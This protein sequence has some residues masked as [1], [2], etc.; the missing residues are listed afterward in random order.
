[1]C[2]F[3]IGRDLE[4]KYLAALCVQ[5]GIDYAVRSLEGPSDY[6]PIWSTFRF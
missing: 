6:A 4:C 3:R 2:G 5:G 1:T